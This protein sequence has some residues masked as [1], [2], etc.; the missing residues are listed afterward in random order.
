MKEFVPIRRL[1]DV[2]HFR[3]NARAQKPLRELCYD[4]ELDG[5]FQNQEIPQASGVIVEQLEVQ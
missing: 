2:V 4:G 5:H 3:R 1:K